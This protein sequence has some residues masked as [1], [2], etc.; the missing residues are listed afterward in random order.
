MAGDSDLMKSKFICMCHST[1]YCMI[2]LYDTELLK[3]RGS[4]MSSSGSLHLALEEELKGR[5]TL[6][7]LQCVLKTSINLVNK[8]Q[9]HHQPL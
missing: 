4:S 7:E 8:G 9:L 3:G 1:I 5:L 2:N 6:C